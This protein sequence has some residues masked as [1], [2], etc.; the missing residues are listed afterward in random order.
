MSDN[1][2]LL[3]GDAFNLPLADES[4]DVCIADPPYA[5]TWKGK[6]GVSVKD[7]GYVQYA[8]REWYHEAMRVLKPG[9]HL[10][11]VCTDKEMLAWLRYAGEPANMIYWHAPNSGSL[12]MI[13]QRPQGG[14]AKTVRPIL[15]YQKPPIVAVPRHPN[16]QL[17]SNFVE[18]ASIMSSMKEAVDYPNQLPLKVVKFLLAPHS[19]VV[20]DLFSGTGTAA[21]A[22]S[23]F[24]ARVISIDRNHK[25]LELGRKR[26]ASQPLFV[27]EANV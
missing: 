2:S 3:L 9:G 6:R 5:G 1:S 15:D 16:S 11:I 18:A 7:S 23:T 14:R 12:A 25:A 26:V 17:Q 10:Y 8:G 27:L 21:E 19:G 4:V 22:A 13:W 20:L 24:G